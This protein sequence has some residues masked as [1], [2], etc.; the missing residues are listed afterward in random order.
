MQ[1]LAGAQQIQ[2]C[3]LEFSGIFSTI[4]YTLFESEDVETA[5]IER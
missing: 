3:F 1:I 2:I 4:F 5:Y